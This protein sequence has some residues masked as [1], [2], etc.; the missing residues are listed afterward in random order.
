VVVGNVCFQA[1]AKLT[2]TADMK[3]R[4]RRS[5]RLRL[6]LEAAIRLASAA[7]LLPV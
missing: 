6:F 5:V 2:S 3:A 4:S 1:V 7:I